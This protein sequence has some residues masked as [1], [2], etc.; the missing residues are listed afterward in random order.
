[1]RVLRRRNSRRDA[2][3][4]CL[5][6]LDGDSR[7]LVDAIYVQDQGAAAVA[8]EQGLAL[9]TIYNKLGVLRRALA[10]CVE[11]RLAEGTA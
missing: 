3:E 9:Q 7:R 10:R 4:A 2:L 11:R 5:E 6:K 8:A 1:M